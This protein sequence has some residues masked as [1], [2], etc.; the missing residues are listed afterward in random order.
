MQ[1]SLAE[2]EAQLPRL[3]RAALAGDEVIIAEQGR[4]S[5]RLV[6]VQTITGKRQPGVWSYL[7]PPAEDWDSPAFNR[8][9]A[10]DLQGEND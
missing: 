7:P 10:K 2:A 6:P 5:V 1:V 4:P 8:E 3:I 9:I